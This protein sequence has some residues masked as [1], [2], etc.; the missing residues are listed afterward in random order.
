LVDGLNDRLGTRLDLVKAERAGALDQA[1]D[2]KR[3]VRGIEARNAE[4]ADHEQVFYR[5][6]RSTVLVRAELDATQAGCGIKRRWD[7]RKRQIGHGASK[8]RFRSA[9]PRAL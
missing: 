1:V 5:R 6:E 7:R 9:K 3:P 8:A 2:R 4:M